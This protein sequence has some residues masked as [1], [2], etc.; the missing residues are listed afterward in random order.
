MQIKQTKEDK[1][2]AIQIKQILKMIKEMLLIM[3]C[4]KQINWVIQDPP[5][6]SNLKALRFKKT[7]K[8]Q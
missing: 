5:L 7:R 8:F 2:L 3:V 4:I 6:R 1:I